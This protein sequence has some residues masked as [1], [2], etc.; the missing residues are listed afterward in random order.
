LF[1]YFYSLDKLY[2][3]RYN[4]TKSIRLEENMKKR[5]ILSFCIVIA[6]IGSAVVVASGQLQN[7]SAYLNHGV[8]I[9]YNGEVQTMFDANGTQVHPITY[10]GTTYL[11]VRAV[12]DMLDVPVDWDA[13][14]NT[15]L[16]GNTPSVAS[17]DINT[18]PNTTSVITYGVSVTKTPFEIKGLKVSSISIER[19]YPLTDYEEKKIFLTVTNNTGY[20]ILR[21]SNIR[22]KC[23]DSDGVV[24]QTSAFFLGDLGNGETTK[25]SFTVPEETRKLI[26]WDAEIYRHIE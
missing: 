10:N 8:T 18:D 9:K 5:V 14:N 17:G 4:L 7:I 16:L 12:A 22:Y 26:F 21:A 3:L 15:V 1:K 24:L 20:T 23:Y 11:P 2:R 19:L 25:V 6:L 13:A